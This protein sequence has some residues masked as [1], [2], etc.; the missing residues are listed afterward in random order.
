MALICKGLLTDYHKIKP[1]YIPKKLIFKG[2]SNK[3]VYNITAP[4]MDNGKWIIAGRVESRKNEF[5]EVMFFEKYNDVWCH[6]ADSPILK[7]QDPFFTRIDGELIIGGVE[8][9]VNTDDNKI[10][11]WRTIMYKG[12]D[13]FHLKLFFI[14]PDGMKDLRVAKL[15]D[16]KVGVFVRPQGTKG[17][18]G[19]IG[20]TKIDTIDDLSVG[21]INRAPL[22]KDFFI[23]TEWGGVNA[24]YP[25]DHDHSGILGHIACFDEEK[26][27]HYYSM[28]FILNTET[29]EHTNVKIIAERENFLAGESK[30]PDLNDVIF[31]G[32]LE[33]MDKKAVLYTGVSDVEAQSLEID[34][35]FYNFLVKSQKGSH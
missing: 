16:G 30:R 27:L 1:E 35:P 3:D 10:Y 24:A 15:G 33:L 13:I 19:K 23:D 32:G 22:L 6:I 28:A 29:L 9:F 12:N 5:S 21:I 7:M 18:R 8:T 17:G 14:G 34:N 31:S 25:L 4:F 26:N 2:I 11:S 20:F